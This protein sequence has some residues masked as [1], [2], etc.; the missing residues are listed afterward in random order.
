MKWR[1]FPFY[2]QLDQMDCGAACLKMIC[3]Y[4][5]KQY[6]IQFLREK[7]GITRQGVS[8][9]GIADA[10]EEVGLKSLGLSMAFETLIEDVTLPCIVHWRQRHFVVIYKINSKYVWVSDPAFGNIR[11]THDKFK[12]GWL[13]NRKIKTVSDTE[14]Y[15]LLFEPSQN[16]Y[17]Q[18][19]EHKKRS[20]NL[21]F[22]L[23]YLK[24]HKFLIAQIIAGILISSLIQLSF[25]FL[26][27]ALVDRGIRFSNINFIYIILAAQLMLFFSQTVV[28]ILR[29]WLILFIS[30]RI[31][32]G[33]I[34]DFLLKMMRL[35]L[36]F[37][38]S[39]MLTDLIQRIE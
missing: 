19:K 33:I 37:F 26:T 5:G 14:G 4:Y 9:A 3:A 27:R 21:S 1:A 11:Y 39:K 32:R 17:E 15:V 31:N 38:D 7:C 35:P 8:I 24:A 16:F 22:L 12:E 13:Y 23:P 18:G 20:Y 30:N 2:R 36:S 6:P 10:A 28:E 25:P 34:S 29:R